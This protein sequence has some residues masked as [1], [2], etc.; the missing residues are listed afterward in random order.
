MATE[1]QGQGSQSPVGLGNSEN[2]YSARNPASQGRS[3]PFRPAI[4]L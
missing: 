3:R 2:C 1:A 4:G